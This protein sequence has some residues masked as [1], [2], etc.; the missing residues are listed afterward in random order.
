MDANLSLVRPIENGESMEQG[1]KRVQRSAATVAPG[2]GFSGGDQASLVRTTTSSAQFTTKPRGSGGVWISGCIAPIS[3][4]DCPR[5]SFHKAYQSRGL[6]GPARQLQ[7]LRTSRFART[8]TLLKRV[9]TTPSTV[10]RHTPSPMR[11]LNAGRQLHR[12]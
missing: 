11:P 9:D 10:A 4:S 5:D 3:R 1:H 6:V 7:Q 8:A 12:S 2:V